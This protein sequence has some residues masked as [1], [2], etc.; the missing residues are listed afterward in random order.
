MDQ[1]IELL[2]FELRSEIKGYSRDSL[3]IVAGGALALIG[4]LFINAS[5]GL[6]LALIFPFSVVANIALGF[7]ILSAAYVIVGGALFFMGKRHFG[8][9][10]IMPEKTMKE[11]KRDKEWLRKEIA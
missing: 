10:H 1:K 4:L 8:N 3:M 2:K 11:L 7:L 9:R 6:F 5:I